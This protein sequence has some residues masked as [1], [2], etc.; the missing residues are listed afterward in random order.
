MAGI[1]RFNGVYSSG[2]PIY[3]VYGATKRTPTSW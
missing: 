1:Y 3:G 2:C